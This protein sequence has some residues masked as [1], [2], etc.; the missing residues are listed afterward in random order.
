MPSS[1][2]QLALSLCKLIKYYLNH[3]R[4]HQTV[5]G[6]TSICRTSKIKENRSQTK[7]NNNSHHSRWQPMWILR[8]VLLFVR[9]FILLFIFI[10]MV[11]VKAVHK[12]AGQVV[13]HLA[14]LVFFFT[15]LVIK[16]QTACRYI[17]SPVMF[18]PL[19]F[20][21]KRKSFHSNPL[22]RLLA[23]LCILWLV[24][25]PTVWVWDTDGGVEV[26]VSQPQ[27]AKAVS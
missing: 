16:V 1:C 4:F 24:V 11:K 25:M 2:C 6:F 22:P 10:W 3:R 26:K 21:S 13:F 19:L 17:Y 18:N 12:S 7:K 8:L 9:V 27:V 20:K 23:P 5:A 15:A 14:F